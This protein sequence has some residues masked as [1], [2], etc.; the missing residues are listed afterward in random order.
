MEAA[1]VMLHDQYLP[2]HI[3]AKA[4]KTMVYVQN[5]T[6]HRVIKN[7]TP[8]EVFSDKKPKVIHLRIFSC[9]VYIH[10]PK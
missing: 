10:I 3:W 1:R 9:L 8:E 7:K 4:A 5:R 6:P 2:M